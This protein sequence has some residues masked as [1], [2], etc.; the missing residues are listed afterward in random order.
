MP[1]I[2]VFRLSSCCVAI[3]A[4][5]FMKLKLNFM[6]TLFYKKKIILTSCSR[7]NDHL[8]LARK[9]PKVAIFDKTDFWG[10]KMTPRGAGQT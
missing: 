3:F 7:V 1:I 6:I 5:I 4:T 10:P 2:G 9:Q 8:I